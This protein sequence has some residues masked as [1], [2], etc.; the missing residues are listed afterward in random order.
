MLADQAVQVLEVLPGSPAHWAGIEAGDVI[1]AL[2]DRLISNI[3]DLHRLL[4]AVPLD[5]SFELTVVRRDGLHQKVVA[6]QE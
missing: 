3:D 5:R 2:N 1:T 4:S 6:G